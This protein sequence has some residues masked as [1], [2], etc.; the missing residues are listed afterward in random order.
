MYKAIVKWYN[1]YE[2]KDEVTYMM[3]CAAS[4][5]EAVSRVCESFTYIDRIEI[6]EVHGSEHHIVYIPADLFDR[7]AE[8]NFY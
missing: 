8:E 3:I 7:I 1:D 6:E 4:Y 2:E 5:A